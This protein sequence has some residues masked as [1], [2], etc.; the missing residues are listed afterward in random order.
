MMAAAAAAAA[1]GVCVRRGGARGGGGDGDDGD[2]G[3]GHVADGTLRAAA[4]RDGQGE[5]QAGV[6]PAKKNSFGREWRLARCSEKTF[7]VLRVCF[8]AAL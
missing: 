4:A 5:A 1:A 2:G 8:V 3:C 7:G 6:S